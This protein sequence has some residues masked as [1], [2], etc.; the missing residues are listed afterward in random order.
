MTRGLARHRLTGE[1]GV[2]R[3]AKGGGRGVGLH[4]LAGEGGGTAGQQHDGEREAERH[5]VSLYGW[6]RRDAGTFS[7]Y[8]GDGLGAVIAQRPIASAM[9]SPAHAPDAVSIPAQTVV[10]EVTQ[11]LTPVRGMGSTRVWQADDDDGT[12]RLLPYAW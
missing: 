7:A 8:R 9:E 5:G 3:T 10:R 12:E 2:G 1:V 6:A 11:R 4:G